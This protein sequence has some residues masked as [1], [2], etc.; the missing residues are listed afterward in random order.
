MTKK[1]LAILL[2]KIK[3][4]ENPKV[5]LEQYQTESE[6]A[7]KS[8]W[9]AFLN[10]DI[11]GK[12]VIDL[13]CGTG[14]FGLGC[15][16]LGAKQVYLIDV[17]KEA[18]EIAKKNK[19]FLEKELNKNLNTKFINKD[20]KEIN[21][22]ADIVVQN[23]PFGVKKSHT[24]KLFLIKAMKLAPIIYSFHKI[25]SESFLNKFTSDNSF[26]SKLLIKFRF[27]LKRTYKFHIKKTHH[28][29][30][31]FFKLRTKRFKNRTKK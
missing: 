30:V 24:D 26:N 6:I 3:S 8:L 29:N 23:P 7:A 14:I 27:P 21:K 13:G 4:F 9:T 22:K 1:Q 16:I 15:S 18:L 17:D 11:K 25:E 31:G 28:V 20:I 19:E 12:T 2:S 10:N 5:N